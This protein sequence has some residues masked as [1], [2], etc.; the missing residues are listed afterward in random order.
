MGENNDNNNKWLSKY[1]VDTGKHGQ[2]SDLFYV[3]HLLFQQQKIAHNNRFV[4]FD[5]FKNLKS[6]LI[7]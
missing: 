4:L 1:N 7:F 6:E 3:I 2:M 5:Y